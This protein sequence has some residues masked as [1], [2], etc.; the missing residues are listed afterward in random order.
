M[1]TQKPLS[2]PGAVDSGDGHVELDLMDAANRHG[3]DDVAAD[4]AQG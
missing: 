4:P 3:V 2:H 1:A